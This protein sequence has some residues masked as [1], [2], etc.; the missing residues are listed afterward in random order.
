MKQVQREKGWAWAHDKKPNVDKPIPMTYID[1]Q[2]GMVYSAS[3]ALLSLRCIF[4]SCGEFR[5]EHMV[6]P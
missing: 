6:E 3:C 1:R 2:E 5:C 4:R